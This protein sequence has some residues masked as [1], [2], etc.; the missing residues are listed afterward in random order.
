MPEDRGSRVRWWFGPGILTMLGTMYPGK[1]L[2][3]CLK[4]HRWVDSNDFADHARVCG[5]GTRGVEGIKEQFIILA[6]RLCTDA[7]NLRK[8]AY[9]ILEGRK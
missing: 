9:E 4:C 2:M 1:Y 7:S 6:D 8:L 5:S 3:E